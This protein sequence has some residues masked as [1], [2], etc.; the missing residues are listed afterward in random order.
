MK[1]FISIV[2]ALSCVA[3]IFFGQLH[4]NEKTTISAGNPVIAEASEQ[5]EES[6]ISETELE[7]ILAHSKNWP[8]ASVNTLKANLEAGKPFNIVLLG[9]FALGTS[10]ESWVQKVSESLVNTYGEYINVS[11]LRY[12]LTSSEY[13]KEDKVS[14]L[15]ADEP[16]LVLFEP[17]TLTDNGILQVDQSLGNISTVMEDVQEQS[18][19]TVFILQPPHPL[20]NATFYP[21]QVAEL[22]KFAKK[23]AIPFLNH[24][25]AWPDQTNVELKNYLSEDNS[26]PSP[27]GH[28]LWADYVTEYFIAE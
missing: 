16:D 3:V 5:M 14:E 22:Q 18:P 17:F 13:V 12:D 7:V 2:S 1:V 19:Q 23:N 26:Q 6:Y 25:E 27:E 4:W 20:Y 28:Q 11:I 9:S 8:T 21:V 24:W 10:E 15:L